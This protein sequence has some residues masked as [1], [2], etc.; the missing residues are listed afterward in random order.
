MTGHLDLNSPILELELDA[1][2][3]PADGSEQDFPVIHGRSR[4]GF[5]LTL[6]GVSSI[7]D[8][9]MA[10]WFAVDDALVG[11]HLDLADAAFAE[12]TVVMDHLTEWVPARGIRLGGSRYGEPGKN[13]LELTYPGQTPLRGGSRMGP[14]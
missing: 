13:E 12:T 7:R 9:P 4:G 2:L 3:L 5:E 6:L 11:G 8:W 1:P 14:M 10:T